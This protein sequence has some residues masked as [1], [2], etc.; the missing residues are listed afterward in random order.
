M[1][2]LAILLVLLAGC[3]GAEK[4][5]ELPVFDMAKLA[6][7]AG[8]PKLDWNNYLSALPQMQAEFGLTD[9]IKVDGPPSNSVVQAHSVGTP[10]THYVE[11]L[12]NI[13]TK[14]VNSASV[15]TFIRLNGEDTK[16]NLHD[17][18]RIWSSILDGDLRKLVTE[19]LNSP[20][21]VTDKNV[22]CSK[23]ETDDGNLLFVVTVQRPL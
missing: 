10:R 23:V 16:S 18:A 12:A 1:K 20:V 8:V 22:S 4:E 5:A 6:P 2:R 17:A 15:S 11:V 9:F 13:D 21:I 14:I 3:G 19:G 7:V